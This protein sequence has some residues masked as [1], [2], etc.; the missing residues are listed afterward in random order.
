M[1]KKAKKSEVLRVMPIAQPIDGELYVDVEFSCSTCDGKGVLR[2]TDLQWQLM[3]N[4]PMSDY[5]CPKC[6]GMAP[7]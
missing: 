7:P 4:K 5:S 6:R 2:L 1:S 3:K